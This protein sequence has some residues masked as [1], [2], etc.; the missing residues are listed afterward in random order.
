[1][2]K[3]IS[4]SRLAYGLPMGG[5]IDYLDS[6]TPEQRTIFMTEY[7]NTGSALR[8]YSKN[9]LTI[10]TKAPIDSIVFVFDSNNYYNYNKI[11]K[12]IQVFI[13]NF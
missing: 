13:F 8:L 3:N 1:M 7:Y 2:D 12:N 5:E 10:T 6:L 11:T 9:S 4:I